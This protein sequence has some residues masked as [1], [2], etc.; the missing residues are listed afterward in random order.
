MA[1]FVRVYFISG[2][3]VHVPPGNSQRGVTIKL[4]HYH[5]YYYIYMC[6]AHIHQIK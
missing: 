4:L 2:I 3:H 1:S 6:A 5:H